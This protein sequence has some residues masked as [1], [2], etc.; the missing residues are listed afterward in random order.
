M[1]NGK[2]VRRVGA[3]L[4]GAALLGACDAPT[5]PSRGQSAVAG[6]PSLLVTPGCAGTGGQVHESQSITT[7]QTWTRASSPH[8]VRSTI[9]V[10]AGGRLTI[11]PGAVVCF[12]EYTGLVARGGGRLMIRGLDTARVVLTG[13]SPT[14]GWSGVRLSGAPAGASYLTNVRLEHVNVDY[15]AI[16]TAE[17]HPAYVDSA[18]IRQSGRGVLFMAPGSRLIRSRVDTTTARNAPAVQLWAGSFENSVVR[19][20]AGPGVWVR[21]PG[22]R[23]LGGRIEGSAGIGLEVMAEPLSTASRAVR[24]TG[25][26]TYPAEI[27]LPVLAW[28]YST[29]ALQD[30][31]S[32]NARDTVNVRGGEL[33]SLLTV[34]PR[35]PL[36][37][38]SGVT[39]DSAGTFAAQPGARV[40][41]ARYAGIL[42][43]GGGRIVSRGSAASPVLFTADDPVVGWE[44]LRLSGAPASPSYVTNTRVEHTG[45]TWGALSAYENHR[46]LVDSAVF[47]H[48]LGII[49]RS[50]NSRLSRSR[51]DSTHSRHTAAVQLGSNARIESTLIRGAAGAGMMILDATVQVV[52]CEIRDGEADGIFLLAAARIR[53]CN[54]VNNAGQGVYSFSSPAADAA[55][56]WWG[57]AGGPFAEGGDGAGGEV[58]YSPWRTTP[59][60]LPYVP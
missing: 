23:L 19:R 53:N 49:L 33:R 43:R 16:L 59:Y 14:Q 18:V 7:S 48:T 41:F 26:Q 36:R 10:E 27:P 51:V 47:R 44:G 20:S 38:T 29:P 2:M 12:D 3:W 35:V 32:G 28:L 58:I 22:V 34:G 21:G 6:G 40:I 55:G 39:V 31:L 42:A 24:V 1:R 15:E 30:S 13:H 46:V 50:P 56:N 25:G 8:R 52:S 57:S 17:Q 37:F 45:T 9:Y 11:A 54:L 60:V 5:A 4:A